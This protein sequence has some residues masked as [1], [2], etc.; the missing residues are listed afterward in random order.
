MAKKLSRKVEKRKSKIE[1][2]PSFNLTHID[3]KWLIAFIALV[4]VV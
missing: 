1:H 3:E 4:A 2:T